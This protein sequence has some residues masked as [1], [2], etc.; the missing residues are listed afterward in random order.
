MRQTT[1]ARLPQDT[2]LWTPLSLRLRE[3]CSALFRP[4]WRNSKSLIGCSRCRV[5]HQPKNRS[6]VCNCRHY[7]QAT[8]MIPTLYLVV[9][10]Y[11]WLYVEYHNCDLY[12]ISTIAYKRPVIL[13]MGEKLRLGLNR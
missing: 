1:T 9:C 2:H 5:W 12:A 3:G 8:F 6:L 7:I 4:K 10:I 11:I 13:L